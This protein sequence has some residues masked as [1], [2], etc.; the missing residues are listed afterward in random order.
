MSNRELERVATHIVH[1]EFTTFLDSIT[2][3]RPATQKVIDRVAASLA[4]R[5]EIEQARAGRR[6][7]ELQ[8]LEQQRT[9]LIQMK[10]D[11]LLTTEEFMM[12]KTRLS[13][14]HQELQADEGDSLEEQ[15][16]LDLI[17]EICD[18]MMRLSQTWLDVGPS[19]QQWFQLSV[20]PVGFSVGRIGT[21]QMSCLFSFFCRPETVKTSLV[22][23]DGRYWN[24]VIR[25]ALEFSEI[26]HLAQAK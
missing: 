21:A 12:Q 16:T 5:N 1:E 26:L 19:I 4:N 7:L 14:R 2:P 23:P 13:E 17:D 10:M 11:N 9:Q 6:K 25:E 15:K 18:P 24:Q 20:L 8:R 3:D 22:H